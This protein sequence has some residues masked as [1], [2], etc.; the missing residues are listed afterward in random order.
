MY[1][2]NWLILKDDAKRTFEVCGQEF[3][4]NAFMNRTIGMQR[5]G[6]MVTA[7]TP[8]ITNKNSNRASV[9]VPGYTQEEGLEARLMSQYRVLTMGSV[10]LDEE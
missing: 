6:M 5:L 7:I 2:K 4:T 8:P 9:T 10:D 3:N 1:T